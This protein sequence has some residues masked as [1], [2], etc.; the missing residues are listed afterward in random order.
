MRRASAGKEAGRRSYRSGAF[1]SGAGSS[2]RP[3]CK[4]RGFPTDAPREGTGISLAADGS[5]CVQSTLTVEGIGSP[6]PEIV[7][8]LLQ[9]RP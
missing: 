7:R 2:A 5:R 3:A 8:T 1:V 6:L 9:A 4:T